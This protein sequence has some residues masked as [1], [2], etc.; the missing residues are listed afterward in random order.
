MTALYRATAADLEVRGDGRTVYGLAVPYDAPTE[1]RD[2][3]RIYRERFDVRSFLPHG[4]H[5]PLFANHAH[6][7]DPAALPIGRA[8]TLRNDARGLVGEFRVSETLAGDEALALIRDGA[9]D[10][11][12]VGFIPDMAAD[13]WSATRDAV[14]RRGARL[15]EVSVVAFP[16]YPGAVIAGL[17][18][19]EVTAVESQRSQTA[20]IRHRVRAR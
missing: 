2:A 10:A 7:S 15:L 3:G 16:A 13:E 19:E 14:V 4:D 20:R 8:L 12:S 11:F 5:V 1:V 18:S 6:R 17:R 9:L